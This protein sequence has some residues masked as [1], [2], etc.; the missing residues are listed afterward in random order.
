MMKWIG[1]IILLLCCN[2]VSSQQD[3]AEQ[4]FSFEAY[5]QWVRNNHPVIKQAGLLDEKA[6]AILLE[7]R[8]L[9]DPKWKGDF[10]HKSFDDKN[11]FRTAEA[12]LKIPT[13][14][15]VDIKL[16]YQW[17]NG[18]FLNQEAT[19]PPNGQ[20][21]IGVDVPL[22]QGLF[23]D[24]RRAQVEQSR[25]VADANE[26]TRRR[27]VNDLLLEAIES[28]WEWAYHYEVV[29]IYENSVALAIDRFDIIRESFLQGDKPA[30]D[31]LE[32]LIVIENRQ[33]QLSQA[34]VEYQNATLQVS[35]Y[36]WQD[37]VV[38]LEINSGLI[39]D[40]LS[41]AIILID[42][43]DSEI[44]YTDVAVNHPT[45]QELRVKQQ[46]LEIKERLK[47]EQFKP[48]LRFN[49]NFLGNGFNFSGEQSNASALSNLLLEN[50]KL[51]FQFN[52]PLLLR[53]ER[54]AMQQ[55]KLEQLDN[56]Y[57]TDY[58]VL[59]IQNK[60]QSIFQLLNTTRDQQNTQSSIVRNFQRLLDA[61]NEKFRIGESSIF[62][63]N[64]REQK[65]IEAQMKLLK[66]N[67]E[68]QKLD[69][70]LEWAKGDID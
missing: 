42:I 34:R 64:N 32:S 31:T 43:D 7:S 63:L 39:P 11:Y 50:Y 6:Q 67:S 57:K 37:D 35:N 36:L 30:I 41:E 66:L 47:R 49:Y 3:A 33:Q 27:M 70:K 2:M 38:P 48:D 10:E 16:G 61:E 69:W 60:I 46:Q 12:G 20:A 26:A 19:L 21:I 44:N 4:E 56:E 14:Y 1:V 51:G 59:E 9:F 15:G 54:G 23:F 24:Q 28:Y 62:L 45:I 53:K 68:L 13:W 22:I 18:E 29:K 58:K 55:V 25:L 52:Y 8:G 5:L 17:A 65:L 40:N